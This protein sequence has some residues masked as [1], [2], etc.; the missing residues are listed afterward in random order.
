MG[1]EHGV[2]LVLLHHR[3]QPDRP[4]AHDPGEGLV[5]VVAIGQR[6]R[7]FL[8]HAGHSHA[9]RIHAHPPR[10]TRRGFVSGVNLGKL[11]QNRARHIAEQ[12]PSRA[13]QQ[14]RFG[15]HKA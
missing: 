10:L 12:R 14:G 9:G 2:D 5:I 7:L 4:R 1:P 13:L 3:R 6:Q 15:I 8:K 11:C